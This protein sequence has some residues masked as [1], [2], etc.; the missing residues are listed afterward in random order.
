MGLALQCDA[1]KV[2]LEV[3]ANSIFNTYAC[4]K[5]IETAVKLVCH[6]TGE[7]SKACSILVTGICDICHHVDHCSWHSVVD[8]A[9]KREHFC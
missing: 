3:A 5:G 1:C 7:F 9:C 6:F 4:K 2:A 8:R